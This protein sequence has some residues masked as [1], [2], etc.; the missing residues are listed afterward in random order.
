MIHF[1]FNLQNVFNQ[2]FDD[3]L[4]TTNY[5][6]SSSILQLMQGFEYIPPFSEL[7]QLD[8]TQIQHITE[9]VEPVEPAEPVDPVDPV[10]PSEP[11][12]REI[13]DES[14]PE[15]DIETNQYSLQ[16]TPPRRTRAEITRRVLPPS[17]ERQAR[18]SNSIFHSS[19]RFYSPPPRRNTINTHTQPRYLL[20][21]TNNTINSPSSTSTIRRRNV[22]SFGRISENRYNRPL[23]S[24][25]PT[26]NNS[27]TN[28]N[29]IT[30]H[31]PFINHNNGINGNRNNIH[32]RNIA[33]LTAFGVAGAAI[34]AAGL[35]RATANL[36]NTYTHQNTQSTSTSTRSFDRSN[37]PKKCEICG[38]FTH[39]VRECKHP[40]IKKIFQEGLYCYSTKHILDIQSNTQLQSSNKIQ[41]RSITK[42]IQNIANRPTPLAQSVSKSNNPTHIW[43]YNLSTNMAKTLFLRNL[44]P[45]LIDH[46]IETLKEWIQKIKQPTEIKKHYNKFPQPQ[47]VTHSNSK[48]NVLIA[49]DKLFTHLATLPNNTINIDQHI[50][51]YTGFTLVP[52]RINHRQVKTQSFNNTKI[53]HIPITINKDITEINHENRKQTKYTMINESNTPI[54]ESFHTTCT[55]CLESV[56]IDNSISTNCSHIFCADCIALHIVNRPS[57]LFNQHNCA[58]CRQ[59]I[60][61]LY[62]HPLL[63]SHKLSL[64]QSAIIYGSNDKLYKKTCPGTDVITDL[65]SNAVANSIHINV[66]SSIKEESTLFRNRILTNRI[67]NTQTLIYDTDS[68]TSNNSNDEHENNNQDEDE[69]EDEDEE[70]DSEIQFN[71]DVQERELRATREHRHINPVSSVQ[72]PQIELIERDY[73]DEQH[74]NQ[75]SDDDSNDNSNDNSDSDN[76]FDNEF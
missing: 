18:N 6:E 63:S 20:T 74:N 11:I 69:D 8:S 7:S 51:T 36:N 35:A 17:I 45:K 38:L 27:S 5:S 57:H 59:E 65:I 75:Y 31:N 33:M 37:I 43:L 13:Q 19:S 42:Q 2:E 24:T 39:N 40:A 41:T 73:P 64:L 70:S 56:D 58:M 76:E 54:I 4:Q 61:Q 66:S 30:N 16:L 67:Q 68:N 10:E 71:L 60:K 21:H 9:P 12:N 34:S 49:V 72:F 48:K 46:S 32:E 28:E 1:P 55:I 29:F 3:E 50:H 53:L 15:T 62:I 25:F 52:L 14:R 26:I 22:Q 47:I 44:D 23:P